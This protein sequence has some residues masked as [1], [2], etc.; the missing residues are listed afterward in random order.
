MS[1]NGTQQALLPALVL[2]GCVLLGGMS[3]VKAESAH[4]LVQVD[5]TPMLSLIGSLEGPAGYN[6][7]YRGSPISPPR[8]LISMSIR[9]VLS[10]QDRAVAAGSRSSAA[11]RYQFLRTTLRDLAAK[12]RISLDAP[13][14]RR[15]QNYLARMM[16]ASCGY[17]DPNGDHRAIGNCLSRI[18]AALPVV[19]GRNAGR[20][21][22]HGIAGNKALTTPSRV[23][24]VI[25]ARM[26]QRT[27][28]A[29]AE[30][31]KSP[32]LRKSRRYAETI[33]FPDDGRKSDRIPLR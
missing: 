4:R 31:V 27:L 3:Q 12:G 19:S 9:Q 16:L 11:G 23:V 15:T 18:W 8:P 24:Q 32:A 17:Y 10:F 13:F 20:S 29:I 33:V 28:M 30:P 21:H 1:R 5:D 6:D 14:D 7:F 2:A 26:S 22:Y 25:R